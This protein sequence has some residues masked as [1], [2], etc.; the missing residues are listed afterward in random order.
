MRW[1]LQD[2]LTITG[3]PVISPMNTFKYYS[4]LVKILVGTGSYTATK[5]ITPQHVIRATRILYERK[6]RKDDPIQIRFSEGRPNYHARRFIKMCKRANEPFPI[7][8][9]QLTAIPKRRSQ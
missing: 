9:V 4:Q 1:G 3:I 2:G 8:K 7:K 6:I 5:Y